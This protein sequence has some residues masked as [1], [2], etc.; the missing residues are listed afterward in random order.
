MLE[1]ALPNSKRSLIVPK[2]Q[3]S[4][5]KTLAEWLAQCGS[6]EEALRRTHAE[7]G[8]T[9]AVMAAE[10]GITPARVGQLIAR[11]KRMARVET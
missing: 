3:R 11:A 6:R 4:S 5:T 2:A 7:S 9:M 8:L 10:L 1:A